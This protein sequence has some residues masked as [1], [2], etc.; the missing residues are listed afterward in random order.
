MSKKLVIKAD[1]CI[2]YKTEYAVEIN[3]IGIED[4]IRKNLPT[5]MNDGK[6]HVVK[7]NIS[8][9]LHEPMEVI[10]IG[11]EEEADKKE[12]PPEKEPDNAI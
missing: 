9:E 1:N 10:K 3:G 8:I 12:I 4:L 2:L 11:Y 5:E 6:E 7:V